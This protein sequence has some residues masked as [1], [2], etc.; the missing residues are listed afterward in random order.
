MAFYLFD[1][2]FLV[3]GFPLLSVTVMIVS[4]S[5]ILYRLH[6][7]ARWRQNISSSGGADGVSG[8]SGVSKSETQLYKMLVAVAC[9][10]VACTVPTITRDMIRSFVPAFDF[11]G[12]YRYRQNYKVKRRLHACAC[13]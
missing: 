5:L 2:L 4:T 3:F 7:A 13:L 10:H 1:N 12:H 9:V 11:D 8:G 6:V